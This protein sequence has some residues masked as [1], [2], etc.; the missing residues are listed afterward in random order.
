MN[1]KRR[2]ELALL[3]STDLSKVAAQVKVALEALDVLEVDA[4]N[5]P[6]LEHAKARLEEAYTALR[7][8][9]RK[10]PPA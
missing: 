2:A 4:P 10:D 1:A 6:I 8:R 3:L 7:G 9:P 5:A